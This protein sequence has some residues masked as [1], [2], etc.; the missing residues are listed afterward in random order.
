MSNVSNAKGFFDVLSP[1][2]GLFLYTL[3][4]CSLTSI[5]KKR[6]MASKV[7]NKKANIQSEAQQGASA[8]TMSS[9]PQMKSFAMDQPLVQ[10]EYTSGMSGMPL[11]NHFGQTKVQNGTF[12]TANTQL[13][14]STITDNIKTEPNEIKINPELEKY[15]Q[16]CINWRQ[17]EKTRKQRYPA[18]HRTFLWSNFWNKV[19]IF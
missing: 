8:I 5:R 7:S 1:Q 17:Y 12:N 13:L 15:K 9:K 3:N 10:T 18:I 2:T 19:C 4:A 16:I 6:K 11:Q 14:N